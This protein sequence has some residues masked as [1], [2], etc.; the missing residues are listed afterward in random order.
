MRRLTFAAFAAIVLSGAVLLAKPSV[1][2]LLTLPGQDPFNDR[3]TGTLGSNW[4]GMLGAITDW[5]VSTNAGG[6]SGTPAGAYCNAGQCVG[7]DF[8]VAYWNVDSFTT[9]Q[10]SQAV[11][12]NGASGY[13]GVC[14]NVSAGPHGYCA[15]L[16]SGGHIYEWNSGARS[17][18][19]TC[20]ITWT[21]GHTLK[22][23]NDGSGNLVV[24]DNG[25]S[26]CTATN[27]D[28]TG[29]SAGI[30]GYSDTGGRWLTWKGDNVGG[31]G[32]ATLPPTLLINPMR[33][34]CWVGR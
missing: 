8:A 27:T 2:P 13:E 15:I 4:T 10:Y 1:P 31:G 6:C 32:G 7:A 26:I 11:I 12:N 33:G 9:A 17:T 20:S 29:G 28:V 21:S 3:C 34:C 14:V 23:S 19:Q 30:G 25:S 16:D 22:L 18:V 5:N 24:A